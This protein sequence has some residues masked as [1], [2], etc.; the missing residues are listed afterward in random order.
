[1]SLLR[2]I[3]FTSVL[4]G[5]IVGA[6]VSAVQFL[7]TS[8]LILKAEVYE[9]A[10]DAG[11]AAPHDHGT[12]VAHEH[13]DEAW[14]P[15][16]GF[17]RDAYT[18]A[19][20]ILTAIGYA[21]VLTGFMA[22]RGRPVGWREGLLW[23]FAGFACVMLAPMLGLPPELPGTPAAPLAVRQLWWIGTVSATAIGLALLAFMRRPWTVV[24]A[25]VLI[26]APHLIGA[27]T[28]TAG[29]EA[30]APDSLERQFVAAAV[31]TSLVFWL[32]LGAL[33]GPIMRRLE[34]E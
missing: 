3:M 19:A 9:T 22:L 31:L 6:A 26:G 21:L 28:P 33:S 18:L 15:A 1:M 23:G 12:A 13:E 32:L 17:E 2:S 34:V 25:I 10:A 24:A 27:P 11:A 7:G 5:F 14:E 29:Q 8:Q 16:D 4:V 20:N 30:L